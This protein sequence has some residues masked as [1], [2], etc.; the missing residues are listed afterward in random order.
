MSTSLSYESFTL[1]VSSLVSSTSPSSPSSW[2][3]RLPLLPL[4]IARKH[5]ARGAPPTYRRLGRPLLVRP[6][7]HQPCSRKM[8]A[9]HLGYVWIFPVW[10]PNEF[11]GDLLLEITV[12]IQHIACPVAVQRVHNARIET[13]VRRMA[14]CRS[15]V[16][17][18]NGSALQQLSWCFSRTTGTKLAFCG[19]AP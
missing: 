3:S 10:R 4:L 9:L 11:D 19:S 13:F 15:L 8:D 16:S 18:L 2:P 12:I 5:S 7:Q 14:R 6:A 17:C 1:A